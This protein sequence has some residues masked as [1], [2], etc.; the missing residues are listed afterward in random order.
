MLLYQIAIE[1]AIGLFFVSVILC[2]NFEL[3]YQIFTY[4][5]RS[6]LAYDINLYNVY[7][8]SYII[9]PRTIL[10]SSLIRRDAQHAR[11]QIIGQLVS[12]KVSFYTGYSCFLHAWTRMK[13]IVCIATWMVDDFQQP[14]LICL[15]VS[16]VLVTFTLYLS[17]SFVV[18]VDV[19]ITFLPQTYPFYT[20]IFIH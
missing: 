16:V 1:I 20:L 14:Y 15:S 17:Y 8:P 10:F 7:G 19:F 11:L 3:F 9:K 4:L 18:M 12:S 6:C 13:M 5:F 2:Q